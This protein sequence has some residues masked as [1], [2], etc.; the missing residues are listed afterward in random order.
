MVDYNHDG[1]LD[2]AGFWTNGTASGKTELHV[3]DGAS[4]FQTFSAHVATGFGPLGSNASLRLGDYTGDGVLDLVLVL[5]NGTASGKVDVHVADGA[6]GYQTFAAHLATSISAV[7]SADDFALTGFNNDGKL[8]LWFLAK[9]GDGLG[10]TSRSTCAA[11]SVTTWRPC[12]TW[13]P[14]T[15]RTDPDNENLGPLAFRIRG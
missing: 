9:Y 5:K 15:P 11:R 7:P 3:L 6:T 4:N 1:A 8:D 14:A 13:P 12:S 10:A 2:L